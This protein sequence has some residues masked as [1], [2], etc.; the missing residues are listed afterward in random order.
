MRASAKRVYNPNKRRSF[1]SYSYAKVVLKSNNHLVIVFE[2][3][4][5]F[6][7]LESEAIAKQLS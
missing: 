6:K 7:A 2:Q 5:T 4:L 1:M 3:C